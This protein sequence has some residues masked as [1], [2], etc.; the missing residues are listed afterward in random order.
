[1]IRQNVGTTPH[2]SDVGVS[3][4]S[5]TTG[6]MTNSPQGFPRDK[7]AFYDTF[8]INAATHDIRLGGS[9]AAATTG[10]D[11]HFNERGSFRFVTDAPFDVND[12]AT[13]PFSFTI[14]VPGLFEYKSKQIGLFAQDT[15]RVADRIRVNMGVRYDVDTNLRNNDF[16]RSI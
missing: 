15:W 1:Y 8:Y 5:A 12:P 7:Y 3:R 9:V 16:Y 6:Q 4:P 2:S 10:F 13:W 14:G 11:S